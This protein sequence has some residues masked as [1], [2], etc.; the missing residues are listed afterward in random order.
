MGGAHR[1]GYP[2]LCETVSSVFLLLGA[3][4]RTAYLLPML[5]AFLS[6]YGMFWQLARRVTG[7]AAKA[8]LAFYLFMAVGSGLCIFSLRRGFCGHLHRFLHNTDQFC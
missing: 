1:F 4:L 2:F 5:P 8:S 3:D 7:S 6:V